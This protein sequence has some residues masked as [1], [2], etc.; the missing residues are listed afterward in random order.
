MSGEIALQPRPPVPGSESPRGTHH[1]HLP[2]SYS[3]SSARI[4]PLILAPYSLLLSPCSL[5]PDYFSLLVAPCS[6]P[7]S[8]SFFLKLLSGHPCNLPAL[9][10]QLLSFPSCFI[11]LPLLAYLLLD[12]SFPYCSFCVLLF[13]SIWIQLHHLFLKTPCRECHLI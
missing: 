5:L 6:L 1:I 3:A 8:L 12:N 7:L 9:L 2:P 13:V 11:F 10:L 4:I